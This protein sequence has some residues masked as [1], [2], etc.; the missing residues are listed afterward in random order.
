MTLLPHTALV[1]Y[2]YAHKLVVRIFSCTN[3]RILFCLYHHQG[4]VAT[5]IW[6]HSKPR[7]HHHLG[8]S[9]IWKKYVVTDHEPRL[10]SKRLFSTSL[11][12]NCQSCHG[13]DTLTMSLITDCGSL[14]TSWLTFTPQIFQPING[15]EDR[16]SAA[17]AVNMGSIPGRVKPKIR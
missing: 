2:R 8:F 13:L 16:A 14:L 10:T 15:R 6:R 4:K 1:Q 12:F 11:L 9:N 5:H 7:I 3:L 17:E